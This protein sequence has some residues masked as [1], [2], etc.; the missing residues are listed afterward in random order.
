MKK[1]RTQFFYW[2]HFTLIFLKWTGNIIVV[3]LTCIVFNSMTCSWIFLFFQPE[4]IHSGKHCIYI[5]TMW[6]ILTSASCLNSRPIIWKHQ[7]WKYLARLWF[8]HS[9][10]IKNEDWKW[11]SVGFLR[12]YSILWNVT[13]NFLQTFVPP[14]NCPHL[15]HSYYLI[16]HNITA[17]RKK[18]LISRHLV[19]I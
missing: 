16:Y 3:I 9:Y 10:E 1:L 18:L 8:T 17:V 11:Y 15:L 6:N 19:D 4:K 5:F 13:C 14:R 12:L 7:T 2:Q